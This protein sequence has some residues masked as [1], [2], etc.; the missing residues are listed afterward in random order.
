MKKYTLWR[1][2]NCGRPAKNVQK[3]QY[4]CKGGK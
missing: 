4:F 3:H 1:C 2:M